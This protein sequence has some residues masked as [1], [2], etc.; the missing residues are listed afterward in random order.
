M[1]ENLR[2]KNYVRLSK[3]YLNQCVPESIDKDIKK[4]IL[5]DSEKLNR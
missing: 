3:D 5:S 1:L 2:Q 4:R